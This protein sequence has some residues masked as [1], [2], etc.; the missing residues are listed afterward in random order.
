MYKYM[1]LLLNSSVRSGAPAGFEERAPSS[2]ALSESPAAL[3]MPARTEDAPAEA[4]KKPEPKADSCMSP[5]LSDMPAALARPG[6]D[7]QPPEKM[8]VESAAPTD[9][10]MSLARLD[11]LAGLPEAAL[12]RERVIKTDPIP[13]PLAEGKA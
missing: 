10:S 3:A 6:S 5:S 13:D 12:D 11:P 9:A 7:E 2:A 1:T 8:D 4:D